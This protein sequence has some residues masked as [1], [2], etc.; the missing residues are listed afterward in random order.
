MPRG[1]KRIT[2]SRNRPSAS[3]QVFGKYALENERTISSTVLATN[4]AT[5][6][7]QPARMATKTNSPEVVQ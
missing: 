5:T 6:L 1:R 7:C 3:C 2:N 4:T